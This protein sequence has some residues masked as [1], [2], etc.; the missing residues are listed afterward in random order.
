[1]FIPSS[2]ERTAWSL[3][4]LGLGHQ[5]SPSKVW[6]DGRRTISD[7]INSPWASSSQVSYKV[8]HNTRKDVFNKQVLTFEP[9]IHF[10]QAA[11]SESS[12]DILWAAKLPTSLQAD[13]KDSDQIVKRRGLI[14]VFPG[15]TCYL[16]FR[17]SF[18]CMNCEY[19]LWLLQRAQ[20][21]IF[22]W[23][24]QQ[25]NAGIFLICYD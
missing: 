6:T 12:Q 25:T 9:W 1:M 11:W 18:D 22:V 19:A 4:W 23:I 7:H 14:R 17:L 16:R 20:I 24:F 21:K 15:R 8:L 13:G 5:M 2:T 3:K 10:L